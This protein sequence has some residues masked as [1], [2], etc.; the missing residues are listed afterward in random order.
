MVNLDALASRFRAQ[1]AANSSVVL[2]DAVLPDTVRTHIRTAFLTGDTDLTVTGVAKDG[3]QLRDKTTLT[4]S[5]GTATVLNQHDVGIGLEFSVSAAELDVTITATMASSW[6]FADSFDGLDTFPFS[7]LAVSDAVFVYATTR[8]EDL[9]LPTAPSETH[10]VEQ[11][12]NFFAGLSLGGFPPLTT[13]L[14]KLISDAPLPCSGSFGPRA[15]QLL[16]VGTIRVPLAAGS[17]AIGVPPDFGLTLDNPAIAVTVGEASATSPGQDVGLVVEAEFDHKL[18][19]S[20]GLPVSGSAVSLSAEPVP[21]QSIK[22]LIPLLPGGK[23][24][25]DHLP[26]EVSPYFDAIALDAFTMVVGLPASVDLIGL[27]IGTTKP[28]P[29]ITDVLTMKKM[30]FRIDVVD[31]TGEAWTRIFIAAEAA[32]LPTI[33]TGPFDFTLSLRHGTSWELDTITGRYVGSVSLATIAAELLGDEKSVPAALR[34]MTLSDFGAAV[35]RNGSGGFTYAFQGGVDAAFP[36][37]DTQ[38]TAH[39]TV[40]VTAGAARPTIQLRGALAVGPEDFAI[41]LDLGTAGAHLSASWTSTGAPL[42]FGDIAAAFGWTDM[43]ALPEG[44]DLALRS[45]GFSYDFAGGLVLTATSANYGQLVFRTW[46]S[47]AGRQYFLDLELP[48]DVAL[49]DIPV[50]GRQ[51]P[52]ALNVGIRGVEIS[53]GSAELTDVAALNA[54]HGTSLQSETYP[55]GMEFSAVLAL[56]AD[57]QR[58]TLALSPS[59]GPAPKAIE[60]VGAASGPPASASGAWVNVGRSFGPLRIDRIGMQYTNG[61]LMFAIDAGI[62]FGPLGMSVEGLAV[63]S[64]VKKFEPVFAISGLGLAYDKAPVEIV[65]GILRLPD[66]QLDTDV[67]FQFDGVLVVKAEQFGLAAVGSYAQLKSGA[68]SL[69]VFAQFE[70]QLGGPPAFF[71]TGLM[72]GFGFNRT[73]V[74]PAQDEVA[75]FPLLRLAGSDKTQNPKDMLGLLEGT[76]PDGKGKR[77]IA[78][79]AG[80]YWLA[81]GLEFTSF[82]LISTRAMLAV[83]FGTEL[84]IALLGLSTMQ[85]PQ[86]AESPE[87]YAYVE[88]MIRVVVQPTQGVFAAT[89]ILSK[90]SYLITPDGHLTGGFAFSLWFGK[91]PYAGQFVA[92]LGGYH[93]A[94]TPLGHYPLV[95]RLGFNWAVSD[96]VSVKGDAYFAVTTSCAMAG[97]GLEVLFNDGGLRAWFTAHADFLVSWR[98][99]QYQANIAVSI[100]VSYQLSV[101]GCHKTITAAIGASLDLHGP[102]TS[103]IARV[104]LV[105]VSFSV[106]FGSDSVAAASQK[107]LGWKDFASL[108]PASSVLCRIAVTDGLYRSQKISDTGKETRLFVRAKRFGFQTRS[109]IP[110]SH[111]V[112]DAD[113][114]TA[115]G[116]AQHTIAVRPMNVDAVASTHSV[117]L[118]RGHDTVPADTTG[119]TMTGLRQ[120]VPGA[121]WGAPP[122]PF[123]QIPAKPSAELL[124]D[125]L[126]GLTVTAPPPALGGSRGPIAAATLATEYL[127]PGQLPLRPDTTPSADYLPTADEHSLGLLAQIADPTATGARNA[128]FAVLSGAGVQ[129][130][131]NG[132]VSVLAAGAGHLFSDP[133]MR[134]D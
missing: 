16:P 101:L 22:D 89:A 67:K 73:L 26:Q 31:P 105:V 106:R 48:L 13:L 68:A 52:T 17:F 85:L 80:E 50:V 70:G 75:D 120:S 37:L 83:E 115:A 86:A 56:G 69:F 100:G 132:P 94:F 24:F 133:P 33:F 5:G 34:G 121:L 44:L 27:S 30:N 4:V 35:T 114:H 95:P 130:G 129:A 62:A 36:L 63:G 91:S 64:P 43:P 127:R 118:Y 88:M 46:T 110:V 6:T 123:S 54:L 122:R 32:F 103:G 97:G 126:V 57:Q 11:G 45:A 59:S 87:T 41:E 19:V 28:W 112:R 74:L 93:P 128:L 58:L 104:N 125:Q 76:S 111:A 113:G 25:A 107:P 10:V 102:P 92:T 7:Q 109:A 18:T 2:D 117:R 55:K 51:I 53:Y 96:V 82:E 81:A 14:G 20:V 12:M 29:L 1:V 124:T 40:A 72:G 131:V 38:L 119:W 134:Q 8:R 108:L 71:V 47:E 23:N 49:S 99:F 39:L 3:I 66:D 65:G 77:W 90:N 61:R 9:R 78:P 98:P 21:G 84:T 42:E 15:G 116:D 60:R 79:K